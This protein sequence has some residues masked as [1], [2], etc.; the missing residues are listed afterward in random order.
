MRYTKQIS[1]LI[2]LIFGVIIQF[3]VLPY[4]PIY[5]KINLIFLFAFLAIYINKSYQGLIWLILAGIFLDVFSFNTY[6]IYTLALVIAALVYYLIHNKIISQKNNFTIFIFQVIFL[7]IFFLALLP[8]YWGVKNGLFFNF[9]YQALFH[10]ILIL[11]IIVVKKIYIKF[12]KSK[13][14][15]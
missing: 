15:I 2:L 12:F 5:G 10:S 9:L 7:I 1:L 14:L 11:I 13:F 3:A 4:L 6:F 8:F